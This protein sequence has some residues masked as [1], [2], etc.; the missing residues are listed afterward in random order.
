MRG[1][2]SKARRTRKSQIWHGRSSYFIG[3]VPLLRNELR[4]RHEH[5]Q[6]RDVA[7]SPYG[8]YRFT[9]EEGHAL[10]LTV[11]VNSPVATPDAVIPTTLARSMSCV[12][13]EIV[14]SFMM[15][16][17]AKFAMQFC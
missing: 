1:K 9:L 6:H 3:G 4:G 15:C 5:H 7:Y 13:M 14:W 17:K 16:P 11:F 8:T 2:K 10:S 12:A